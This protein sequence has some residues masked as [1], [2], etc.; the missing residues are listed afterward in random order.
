MTAKE[1]SNIIIR[2]RQKGWSEEEINDFFVYVGTHNPS[3]AE[4]EKAR[5]KNRKE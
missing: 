5:E 4:A 1:V 2:L 3:E